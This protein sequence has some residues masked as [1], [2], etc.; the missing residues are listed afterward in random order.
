VLIRIAKRIIVEKLKKNQTYEHTH[1][2]NYIHY[3]VALLFLVY[4][5]FHLS[6]TS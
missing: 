1:K 3:F 5:A 2:I 6:Y 4:R